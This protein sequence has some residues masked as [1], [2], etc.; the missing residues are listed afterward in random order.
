M[1]LPAYTGPMGTCVKCGTNEADTTYLSAGICAHGDDG[2]NETVTSHGGDL[3]GERLHRTCR[4][5]GYQWDEA[6]KDAEQR[7]PEPP[8]WPTPT[9][10]PVYV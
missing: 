4:R 9:R 1:T 10:V 7:H 8:S 2:Y 5:C 6:C 3:G